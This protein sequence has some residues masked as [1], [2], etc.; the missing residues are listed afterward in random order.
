MRLGLLAA[1]SSPGGESLSEQGTK[2]TQGE[3]PRNADREKQGLVVSFEL[4][5]QFLS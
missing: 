1:I 5:D 4:L 2:A 3:E